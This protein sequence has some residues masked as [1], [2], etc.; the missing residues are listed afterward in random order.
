[1]TWARAKELVDAWYFALVVAVLLVLASLAAG[2]DATGQRWSAAIDRFIARRIAR[3]ERR[4][5][6]FREEVLSALRRASQKQ[7]AK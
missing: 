6:D 5:P 1:M 7:G 3:A 4:W 2:I